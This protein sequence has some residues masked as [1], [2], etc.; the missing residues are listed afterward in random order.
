[1]SFSKL[2]SL[3]NEILIDIFEKYTNGTDVILAF[4]QHLNER[5]DGLI[6]QCHQL[7]FNFIRCSKDA[8][9]F[10][11]SVLPTYI[12]KIEE[13]AISEQDT[14][15][16]IYTFLS[17]FPSFEL[18]QQLR[19]FYFHYDGETIESAMIEKAFHSLVYTKIEN[20]SIKLEVKGGRFSW[21]PIID[22]LLQLTTLKRFCFIS[23][24]TIHIDWQRLS[25]GFSPNMTSLVLCGIYTELQHV[26]FISQWA[27][28]LKYLDLKIY[29]TRLSESQYQL[30]NSK[31]TITPLSE[32]KTLVWSFLNEKPIT[33]HMLT[34]YLKAMPVLN[35]LEIQANKV[36]ID[37]NEWMTLLTT[38]LPSVA[39][40]ILLKDIFDSIPDEIYNL[41]PPIRNKILI[42]KNDV[43]LTM[44]GEYLTPNSILRY[45]YEGFVPIRFN[46]SALQYVSAFNRTMESGFSI[47]NNITKLYLSIASN[48]MSYQYYFN[49]VQFL[50]VDEMDTS[51]LKWTT[52]CV[53]CLHIQELIITPI[54]KKTNELVRF[55]MSLPNL[56]SLHISFDLLRV[57]ADAFTDKTT[58]LKCLDLT[59]CSHTFQEE[60]II[61]IAKLFPVLEHLKIY[62][63][64]LQYIC[65]L[66]TYLPHLISLTFNDCKNNNGRQSQ[67]RQFRNESSF[68]S[69]CKQALTTVWLNQ[70]AYEELCQR[71]LVMEEEQSHPKEDIDDGSKTKS[72]HSRFNFF[73]K[74]F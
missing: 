30:Q 66:R 11:M 44:G 73:K 70:Q 61:F 63:S 14:P 43:N 25:K 1:M 68:L 56:N 20:L 71:I 52:T 8:F 41:V 67:M 64:D 60:D 74:W 2:E 50:Q 23:R 65:L 13:L 62:T 45:P 40:F 16:Q 9:H 3:P 51:L 72:A 19:S 59:V 15:G 55:L 29:D 36:S 57:I 28:H 47:V 54:C 4:N 31:L 22:G 5:F 34:P 38:A 42:P 48:T 17:S 10:C 53:N 58:S 12:D 33:K 35:R 49:N 37:K 46:I 69:L 7:R 39:N 24:Y 26:R 21:G 18:F 6:A 27:P 32:L